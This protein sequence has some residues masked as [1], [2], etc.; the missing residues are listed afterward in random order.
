[1]SLVGPKRSPVA[2][3]R[4]DAAADWLLGRINYERTTVVPYGERQLKLDRM[5]QF[6]TALGSPD[7]AAPIVHIAGTK[8]KG[9]TAAMVASMLTAAGYR[10]GVFSS[11]H[12]ERLE[13]RFSIDGLPVTGIQ[14]A[15]LVDTVR[16]VV[17]EFDR[18][19]ADSGEDGLTFFDITTA[20]ALVHFAQQQCA[21]V[22]LEVGLGGRLDST[23]VC[24]PAVSV[25]TSISLDHTKQLGDTLAAIAGEKAGIVKPGVP[26][27]SGVVHHE[28][29][30]V[31][32]RV[33]LDHGCRL[34]QRGREFDFRY[35]HL[36]SHDHF[37]YL[38]GGQIALDDL[39]L[40]LAGEHQAA[41]AAVALAVIDELVNQGWQVPDQ[42]RR[43]GLATVQLAGRIELLPGEPVVVLDT[44]HNAASAAALASTIAARGESPRTLVVSCSRDKDF[45]AIAAALTVVF[46]RV[47]VTEYQTN[48]RVVSREELAEVFRQTAG[49]R[50]IVELADTPPAALRRAVEVTPREGLV[51]VAGSFFLAAELRPVVLGSP[52]TP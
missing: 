13:E 35:R 46:E 1:M 49:S 19:A 40:A 17:E 36:A 12:L 33:A 7:T 47:I 31:I 26:V 21:A 32:A 39:E 11:P 6:V 22:V 51:C 20:I 30:E 41:N 3:P 24:L 5:R 14:L 9:S 44:A 42:A 27:V 28:P 18:R 37:D 10:T 48:P 16:P 38:V 50:S 23:N 25:I 45:A 2:D 52:N 15:D 4:R 34:I 29:R 43:Q 8:G